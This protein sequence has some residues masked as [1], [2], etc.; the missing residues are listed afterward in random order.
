MTLR[1]RLTLAFLA[2]VLGPVLLGTV[3][4]GTTVTA[5]N[6]SR[7]S[8]GLDRAEHGVRAA[9]DALCGQLRAVAVL[10]DRPAVARRA[11]AQGLAGA[12]RLEDPAGNPV[13]T[14]DGAPPQP[15]ALCGEPAGTGPYAALAARVQLRDGAGVLLG[16]A[17]AARPIDDA[18]LAQLTSAAGGAQVSLGPVPDGGYRRMLAGPLPLAVSV[19]AP[20]PGA[21]L[22]VL[23]TV[24]LLAAGGA[25]VIASWLARGTTRPLAEL[26]VAVERVGEGDLTV[27]VPVR[28]RDEVGR[29]ATRFNRMTRELQ[30]YV[31]AL[32]ASRD[33]LRGHLGV[34]GDTLSSTHDLDRILEVI[35]QTACA[36]T[37]AVSG[38]VLL[39]SDGVLTGADVRVPLG[40][41]LV[42][43][44]ALSG[45]ARRG[46]VDR[47]GPVLAPGEPACRTYM[48]VPFSAPDSVRGV[49]AL[50]D[51]LGED[52]FDD[53]DLVT[54]RT[55]AGQAA[56]AVENVRVHQEAQRLSHTDPLTGLY[57]YRSLTDSL[58]REVER[59]NRFGHRLCVLALDLDRFKDVNDSYGHAAG[60]AVLVEFAKRVRAVIREVDLAF[61]QGGEEFVVILPETDGPGG[62]TVAQRLG[63]AIR[64]APVVVPPISVPVSVSIG[65]A[66]FPEHGSSGPAVLEIADQALYAAKAAGRNTYRLAG[67]SGGPQGAPPAAG[68]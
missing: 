16:Y 33:Q 4:V 9:V 66:V 15:W 25:V 52:E 56:I 64:S 12:V 23:V 63:A 14:S 27:R 7:A 34:L 45:V 39:L 60:D 47:D 13:G 3:F 1:A 8:E 40:D 37:G 54:L 55:F 41:G 57:N 36:A 46:R 59:A 44:V 24:V 42:G 58:R 2:V 32:T 29:L 62:V 31:A 35:L 18:L 50:Y 5:M 26:A 68:R 49:L 48:A 20:G 43:S 51:R 19:P 61:R 38:V 67:A 6:R 10:V 21:L 53:T 65:I 22:P 28:G 17:Y 30:G 11:V